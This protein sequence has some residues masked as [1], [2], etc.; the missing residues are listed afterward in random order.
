MKL[1][2]RQKSSGF[3][4]KLN[5]ELHGKSVTVMTVSVTGHIPPDCEGCGRESWPQLPLSP[6]DVQYEAEGGGMKPG[7]KP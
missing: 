3:L 5:V 1:R 7:L 2:K 4:I 6:V